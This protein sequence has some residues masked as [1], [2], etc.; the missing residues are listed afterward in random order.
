MFE[1]REQ[2]CSGHKCQ[3]DE[4]CA[5]VNVHKNLAILFKPEMQLGNDMFC[6]RAWCN[7]VIRVEETIT[8]IYKEPRIGNISK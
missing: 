8:T 6:C 1:G 5:Q 7:G 4:T 3:F 2:L